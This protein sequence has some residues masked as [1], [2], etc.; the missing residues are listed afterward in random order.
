MLHRSRK[1][2]LR[3]AAFSNSNLFIQRSLTGIQR[4]GG[5]GCVGGGGVTGHNGAGGG[6]CE[7]GHM[8]LSEG[9]HARIWLRGG[10][11]IP[12][13]STVCV[14]DEPGVARSKEERHKAGKVLRYTAEKVFIFIGTKGQ[15]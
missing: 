15:S 9:K 8:S 10:S 1:T 12:S 5:K 7:V 3:V 2:F 14:R 4:C 6:G 11:Q 13:A